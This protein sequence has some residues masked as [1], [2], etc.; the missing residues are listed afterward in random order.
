[1]V[2]RNFDIVSVSLLEEKDDTPLVVDGNRVPPF[3][4]TRECVEPVA[5]WHPQIIKTSSQINI[6]QSGYALLP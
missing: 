6:F 4:R 1:M 2:I 3:A 5:G